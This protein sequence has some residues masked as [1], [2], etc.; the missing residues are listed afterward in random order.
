[1]SKKHFPPT[2]IIGAGAVGST[3][4]QAIHTKGYPIV[5]V[6][7][8]T[9]SSAKKLARKVRCRIASTELKLINPSTRLIIVAVP[10]SSIMEI[11]RALARLKHL[12]FKQLLVTHTSGMY[13]ASALNAVG[14]KGASVTSLHPIQTFPKLSSKKSPSISLDGIYYGVDCKK[15]SLGKIKK[16]IHDLNGNIVIIPPEL[17]RLY[18]ATCVFA[19]SYFVMLSNVVAELSQSLKLKEPWQKVFS[20]LTNSA[21]NNAR[22]LS[23]ANALTGPVVRGDIIGI[24]NHMVALEQFAP[25]VIPL[26]TFGALEIARIATLHNKLSIKQYLTIDKLFDEIFKQTSSSSKRK[27]KK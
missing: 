7:S 19:S 25:D 21:I 12:N 10:D 9:E 5:S 27:V 16:I 2:T 4:A 26:Y 6:I 23:P 15:E 8:K 20:P 18:H 1:M 11:S 17:R 14:K 3:L 22:T 13:S 24:L